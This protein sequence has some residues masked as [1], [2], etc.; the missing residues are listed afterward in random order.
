[1]LVSVCVIKGLWGDR[2]ARIV[3][4]S[5]TQCVT[6]TWPGAAGPLVYSGNDRR[7]LDSQMNIS[8]II[9]SVVVNYI[10]MSCFFSLLANI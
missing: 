9:Q 6:I 1:M 2:S 3:I 10:I 5:G 4:N 8:A 7:R